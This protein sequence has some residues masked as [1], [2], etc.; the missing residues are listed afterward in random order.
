MIK[1]V[2][3]KI[4]SAIVRGELVDKFT[5]DPAFQMGIVEVKGEIFS[6]FEATD[7]DE[8]GKREHLYLRLKAVKD[9]EKRLMIAMRDAKE[10]IQAD[11]R[12][13]IKVI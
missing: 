7:W 6:E 12:S 4:K 13:K 2:Y 11:K 10:A 9:F 3:N 1:E 8:K 5:M